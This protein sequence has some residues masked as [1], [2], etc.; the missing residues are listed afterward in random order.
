MSDENNQTIKDEVIEAIKGCYDPE[1]PV[2]IYDLGLIYDVIV[3][4]EK[5]VNV[6]MTL[7]SPACPVAGTLPGEVEVRI[8][9]VTGIK[10]V[11]VDIVWD[12][13]W[14]PDMMS[15]AAKLEL[16]MM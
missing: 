8:G 11:K 2:N 3:D 9:E 16:N 6:N 4:S 14:N 15:E 13:P 1:I 12:P 10:D 7:T 5:N